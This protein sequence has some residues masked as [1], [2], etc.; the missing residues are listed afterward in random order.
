[1]R[2][3][4]VCHA[5]LLI[6]TGEL[7]VATDPWFDGP[8]YHDQWHVFPRPVRPEAPG[9]ADVIV[10]SHGEVDELWRGAQLIEKRLR[11]IKNKR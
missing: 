7:T 5:C 11:P 1:M 4:Y 9:E 8:A 3:E 2:V 6:D 10:I